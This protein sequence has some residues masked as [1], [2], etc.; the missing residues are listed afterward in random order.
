MRRQ[1]TKSAKLMAE[2]ILLQFCLEK[3]QDNRASVG[4]TSNTLVPAGG[5][6]TVQTYCEDSAVATIE[7]ETSVFKMLGSQLNAAEVLQQLQRSTTKV[8]N[9][10]FLSNLRAG[11]FLL[12]VGPDSTDGSYQHYRR[13]ILS[14]EMTTQLPRAF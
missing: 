5:G 13:S 8:C 12:A 11:R 14:L 7:S 2:D 6:I 3:I 4:A 9:H 10:V 1:T